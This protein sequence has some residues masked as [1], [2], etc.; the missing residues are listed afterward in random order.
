[1]GLFKQVGFKFGRWLDVA[2]MER[3]LPGPSDAA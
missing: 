3:L 2:Y 1:V